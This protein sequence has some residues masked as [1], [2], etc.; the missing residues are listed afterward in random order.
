MTE[1][2]ANPLND[3]RQLCG[4]DLAA[5]LVDA[6]E[7]TL[8]LVQDLSPRQWLPPQQAGINPV[9]WELAHLA[10]FAEFWILR[11][12]H[13]R[14][15]NGFAQAGKS[16]RFVG[17]DAHFDSAQLAHALRWTTPMPGRAALEG[18][19]REQLDACLQALP[20]QALNSIEESDAA[21]YFHRLALFHE[22][23]HAEALCWMRAA[24]GYTAPLDCRLPRVASSG[25]LQFAPQT[26]V[27]G[28]PANA[29]GF[30]FDNE[31]AAQ[32]SSLSAYEID[33]A[34]LSAARF[35]EFVQDGGYT[36]PAYWP[37]DAGQWLAQSRARHPERWRGDL[38]DT[39]Q[40]RWFDTWVDLPHDA[41]A[42]QLNAYE[43]EAYC[44]WAK[45]RLPTAIEW[46][47]AAVSD[48]RFSWGQSVWEWTASAF[49]PYPG[50]QPGP[51]RE[52]SQ[53][54]FGNHREL[55]GGAFATH[56]RIHHP[57]YRNFFQPQRSDIFA[58]FRTVALKA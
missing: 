2:A 18:L 26:V 29:A 49:T 17:P 8:S 19:M 28:Y 15:G 23:M 50:F 22:D 27:T 12:P 3:A 40:I 14:N 42:M 32:A 47:H 53:P 48:K 36:S 16:P 25:V 38:Q 37:G 44:L 1:P 20:R 34:P 52:Y 9:V 21:H 57:R 43:A 11:G 33:A 13:T 46:E 7:R 51:Y 54:W 55:R 31:R 5:A 41:P 35:V 39:W 24:L 30:S 45:R 58:G 6:R 56:A 4:S 10:W